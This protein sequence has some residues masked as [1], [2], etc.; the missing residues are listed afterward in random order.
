MKYPRLF[1]KFRSCNDTLCNYH[2]FEEEEAHMSNS[3]DNISPRVLFT[4]IQKSTL[5]LRVLSTLVLT[6][7]RVLR[8]LNSRALA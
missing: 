3:R 8:V 5:V 2:N 7:L 1:Q 4:G 6:V